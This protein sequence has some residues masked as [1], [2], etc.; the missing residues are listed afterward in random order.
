MG[1]ELLE[2]GIPSIWTKTAVESDR[3]ESGREFT[4]QEVEFLDK[5]ELGRNEVVGK[6]KH[7]RGK[8]HA[9]G[10]ALKKVINSNKRRA[11][12]EKE[13]KRRE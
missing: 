4:A 5:L 13:A 2:R 7:D 1:T 3:H 10:P 8:G 6:M 9:G 11:R 12:L